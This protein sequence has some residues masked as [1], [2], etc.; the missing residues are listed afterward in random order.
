MDGDKLLPD[1]L[2]VIN[3][4]TRKLETVVLFFALLQKITCIFD[5]KVKFVYRID[6][7]IMM[8]YI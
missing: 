4:C 5:R 1:I 6:D 2:F 3:V 8:S 7:R